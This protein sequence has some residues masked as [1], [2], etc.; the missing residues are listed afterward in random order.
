M[1]DN[2]IPAERFDTIANAAAN[3]DIATVLD[4]FV[5]YH[6]YPAIYKHFADLN[7]KPENTAEENARLFIVHKHYFN[8]WDD[9]ERFTAEVRQDNSIAQQFEKAANTIAAGDTIA[10][11]ELLRENPELVYARSL[12]NHRAMLLHYVGANGVEDWRQKTPANIVEIAEI[13]LNAGAEIDAVGDMYG[14]STT[15][16]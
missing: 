2:S 4:F 14:G 10:L 16:G 3:N 6:N 13:L 5:D 9:Y 7:I 12:R 11:K 1:A 8:S 15:L